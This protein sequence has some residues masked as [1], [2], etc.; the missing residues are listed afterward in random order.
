MK[1]PGQCVRSG[2]QSAGLKQRSGGQSP[3]PDAR[4]RA[5]TG[6]ARLQQAAAPGSGLR[7]ALLPSPQM[8]IRGET[9]PYHPKDGKYS[10]LDLRSFADRPAVVL[11]MARSR[12]APSGREVHIVWYIL[13]TQ[14]AT[15]P[16]MTFFRPSMARLCSDLAFAIS[17]LMV[18]F[19]AR[20]SFPSCDCRVSFADR[21]TRASLLP[22]SEHLSA[23]G[24]H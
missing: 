14:P 5:L 20:P 2:H 17:A 1:N 16:C 15:A 10:G 6:F 7:V 18:A 9:P 12:A 11:G 21:R 8:R 13:R 19:L 22:Q 3:S 23:G 4:R 24:S